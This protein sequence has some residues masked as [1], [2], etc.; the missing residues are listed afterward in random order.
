MIW[1]MEHLEKVR[2][3]KISMDLFSMNMKNWKV[4]HLSFLVVLCN[5]P[6]LHGVVSSSATPVGDLLPIYPR[7]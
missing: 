4:M 1:K 7:L 2:K 3:I 5:G 6:T